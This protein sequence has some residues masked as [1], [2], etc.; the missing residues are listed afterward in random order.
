VDVSVPQ[1]A[2][3]ASSTGGNPA[4]I[5]IERTAIHSDSW[6]LFNPRRWPEQLG[7]ARKIYRRASHG[8][9]IVHCGRAQPEAV[10]ALLAKTMP[11][12]PSYIF[13]AHGEDISAAMSSRQFAMTMRVVYRGA[14]AAIANSENTARLIKSVGWHAG[15]VHVVYPGV[16]STR[17]RPAADDG[18]I[19]RRLAPN[20]ELVILSVSRLQR[21]KGHELVL[22]ALPDLLQDTPHVRYVI[23]GGGPEKARLQQLVASL[24]LNQIVRFEGEV[25]DALLPAYFS[26]CDLFALPTRVEPYDFEG[27]GIV[28]LEAAASAKPAIGGRN[29]GVP[30][31]VVDRKTGLLVS[32]EDVSELRD[33]LR[34]LCSSEQLR[35]DLGH[36]ARAR[37][38]QDFTWERAAAAV[39]EIHCELARR[40]QRPSAV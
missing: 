36:A 32:G 37:A 12:G 6:G 8:R 21:R 18:T 25:D 34:T 23:V 35:R 16:D 2:L 31:A 22:R 40:I 29:G 27:F 1:A 24:G 33:A 3:A 30:E 7:L 9:A 38:V 15:D 28:Y 20:G 26:A 17:F 39:T 13:W 10:P 19:R 11:G 4:H 5:D 14:S